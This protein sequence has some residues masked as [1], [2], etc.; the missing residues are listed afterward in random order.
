MKFKIEDL[1]ISTFT[2]VLK[3]DEIAS[4]V[5]G[6]QPSTKYTGTT[7]MCDATSDTKNASSPDVTC[8]DTMQSKKPSC[9]K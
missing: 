9:I 4:V 6:A 7:S 1:E 3:E 5:G 2:K 8:P